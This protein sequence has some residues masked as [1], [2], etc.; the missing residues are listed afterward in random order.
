MTH[1]LQPI[2][3]LT[4][5]SQSTKNTQL[6]ITDNS[7]T[8]E[9]Y[10]IG[11]KLQYA[12]H[13]LQSWDTIKHYLL[14]LGYSEA[15]KANP[16]MTHNVLGNHPFIQ[17]VIHSLVAQGYLDATQK[18][19]LLQHLTHDALESLLWLTDR[20]FSSSQADYSPSAE[21]TA[22]DLAPLIN[23][24][25]TRLQD[26]Q[27]LSPYL[28]SP[29]Q[30]PH[31]P[32]PAL[33]K[34]PVPGATL[35]HNALNQLAKL[36]RGVSIR[37]LALFVRQDDLKMAQMLVPYIKNQILQLQAPKSPLDQLPQIPSVQP[38]REPNVT[39]I[40]KPEQTST[41]VA[42]KKYKIVCIDDSPTMLDLMETY[43]GTEK[44]EL[45]TVENPMQSLSTLFESKPDLILMDISMPG[46]N[47]NRLS[48]ILKRSSVFKQVPI[49]MV[50]GNEKMLS[51]EKILAAGATD[52]LAKPFTQKS[53]LAIVEKHLLATVSA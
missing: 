46:I 50:S 2:Q 10:L 12:T 25:Q 40:D 5:I 22:I 43:L 19:N 37:Q 36:M 29:H 28:V 3:L 27:K 33:L 15:A 8:W 39:V 14:R 6:T 51:H 23:S 32:N 53:L 34:K 42:H 26:W 47:G 7:V 48:Q 20:E 31:C 38:H 45:L 30:R 24:L 35:S 9:L 16:R 18:T 13:S 17:Q 1:N 4:Q 11:G 41:N 44:Y 21:D 49:I 52:Y